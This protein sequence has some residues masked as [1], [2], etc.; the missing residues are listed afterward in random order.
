MSATI[1]WEPVGTVIDSCI[2]AERFHEW[3]FHGS[4][5]IDLRFLV[6]ERHEDIPAH[7]PDHLEIVFVESGNAGYEVNGE[8]REIRRNDVVVVNDRM[9][10]RSL[11]SRHVGGRSA[12]VAVLAFLPQLLHAGSPARDDL[13]Y[14]MLFNML[15]SSNSPVANVISSS[16]SLSRT[17]FDLMLRVVEELPHN[18]ERS[19]LA[20]RTFMRMML[21][22]LAD[23]F[24]D[25]RDAMAGAG[26]ARADMQ[27]LTP[28]FSYVQEHYGSSLRVAAAA[29]ECAMSS[30]CFMETFKR[31]TGQTFGAYVAQFRVNRA[32]ELLIGTTRPIADIGHEVGFCDQSHFGSVF[33]QST[34]MTPAAFRRSR[35]WI[36]LSN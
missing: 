27:R 24:W 8:A 36:D 16:R 19:R 29:R 33:R 7:R 25:Q 9:F 13:E 32:Q 2:D 23:Y 12:R 30:T 35:S 6:V 14:L 21:F 3:P 31:I 18:D 15:G 28:A 20:V 11:P 22:T 1:L 4:F 26:R 34:G 5:P 17:V 10:H